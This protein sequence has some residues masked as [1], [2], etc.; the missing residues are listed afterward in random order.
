MRNTDDNYMELFGAIYKQ[1]VK[2][3]CAEV[4]KKLKDRLTQLGVSKFA[5]RDYI[6]QNSDLIKSEVQN[7][8]FQ[9]AQ[10]YGHNTRRIRRMNIDKLAESLVEGFRRQL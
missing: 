2:D 9:E 5:S 7:N 10:N 6:T 1:A 8:V 3:D 4:S